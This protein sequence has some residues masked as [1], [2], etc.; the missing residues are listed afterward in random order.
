[1][2]KVVPLLKLDWRWGFVATALAPVRWGEVTAAQICFTLCFKEKS[3]SKPFAP[4]KEVEFYV[5]DIP[6][7]GIRRT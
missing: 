1:M 6:F 4:R 5:V 2:G 3:F 7:L